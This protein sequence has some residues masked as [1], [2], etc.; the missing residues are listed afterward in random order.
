MDYLPGLTENGK[1]YIE[2]DFMFGI[3]NTIDRNYFREALAEIEVRRTNKAVK[4]EE[5]LIEIDE[6]IF[7]LL[8]QVQ[9]RM[10]A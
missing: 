5:G 1:Q 7:C 2:R 3:V 9:S 10:S 8:E 4:G 6:Q